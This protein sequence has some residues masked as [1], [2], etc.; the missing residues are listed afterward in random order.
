[1]TI[2]RSEAEIKAAVLAHPPERPPLREWYLYRSVTDAGKAARYALQQ[3]AKLEIVERLIAEALDAKDAEDRLAALCAIK[4][5]SSGSEYPCLHD[6]EFKQTHDQC[7]K[8]G[9]CKPI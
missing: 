3:E 5:L 6:W 9:V 8:C 7:R 2:D 4:S 1:M